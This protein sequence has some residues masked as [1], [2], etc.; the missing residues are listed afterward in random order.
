MRRGRFWAFGWDMKVAILGNSGSGKSTLARTL[1]G[2]GEAAVP[3]LDLDLVFWQPGV[4][5]ERPVAE[6]EA[7]VRD[8]CGGRESWIVEGC[9]A[10]LIAVALEGWPE[11]V[12]LDPGCEVCVVHCLRREFEP[13]KYESREA[14][15]AGLPFLLD[16]VRGYYER[17][18]PLSLQGH[19]ALYE[20]YTGPKR[21]VGAVG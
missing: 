18:G 15:D 9:Y 16:W 7:M 12:F 13:H 17:E 6:R 10:D 20:A 14:Q 3:V 21:R 1:A 5:V 8:F 19:T 2:Q 11:L 4:P